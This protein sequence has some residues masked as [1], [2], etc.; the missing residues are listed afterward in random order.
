[1]TSGRPSANPRHCSPAESSHAARTPASVVL[2]AH[3]PGRVRIH[4]PGWGPVQRTT[5]ERRLS[6]VPGVRSVR[7][8][9]ST[10][11]VLLIYDPAMTDPATL[12]RAAET[13]LAQP[14]TANRSGGRPR[15]LAERRRSDRLVP[16][17]SRSSPLLRAL[18]HNL[19]AVLSLILSLLTCTTPLAAARL[20]LEAVQVAIKIG[21]TTA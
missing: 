1:M 7:A 12:L 8:T 19:P 10:G 5:L 17:P 11:N 20:G 18:L 2:H 4:I 14:R 16:L 15:P 9:P 13:A 6:M 21:A 3:V